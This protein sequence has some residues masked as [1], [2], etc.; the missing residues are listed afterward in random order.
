M[1]VYNNRPEN[2]PTMNQRR[3]RDHSLIPHESRKGQMFAKDPNTRLKR[4]AAA[5]PP[6]IEPREIDR[7]E[8]EQITPLYI[9]TA[10]SATSSVGKPPSRGKTINQRTAAV[11]SLVPNDPYRNQL[12]AR[13]PNTLEKR[14]AAARPAAIV[15]TQIDRPELKPA[16]PPPLTTAK[17][18]SHLPEETR[19]VRE[20][21][22]A[23]QY[24]AIPSNFFDPNI[25][26]PKRKAPTYTFDVPT[27]PP[28]AS[29]T[30]MGSHTHQICTRVFQQSSGRSTNG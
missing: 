10:E 18:T 2:G 30:K 3:A 25:R 23:F 6:A 11:Q 21:P 29:K 7:S 4:E 1:P 19:G 22:R 15:P 16:V 14:E 12:Y 24:R 26:A 13:Y 28:Q 5:R 20:I 9:D 8:W 17:S 27:I